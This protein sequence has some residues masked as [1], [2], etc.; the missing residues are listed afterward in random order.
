MSANNGSD[1]TSPT[2]PEEMKDRA[3]TLFEHYRDYP[4]QSFQET[5]TE[6]LD[7]AEQAIEREENE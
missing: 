2:V 6:L 4:S 7:L 3:E 5:M 1:Y